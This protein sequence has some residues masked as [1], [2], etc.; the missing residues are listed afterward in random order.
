M[1]QKYCPDLFLPRKQTPAR[2][3]QRMIK[4]EQASAPQL[5]S[6]GEEFTQISSSGHLLCNMG[7]WQ[8]LYSYHEEILVLHI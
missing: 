1:N 7:Q 4:W 5:P 2:L 6:G 8:A 3:I